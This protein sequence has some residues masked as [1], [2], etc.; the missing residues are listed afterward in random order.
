MMKLPPVI[1]L[2]PADAA[3]PGQR[4]RRLGRDAPHELTV[5]GN[6]ALLAE[7]L[8]ALLCSARCSGA[9]IVRAY[10]QAAH[11]RDTGR[12]VIGGFHSPPEQ[13]CLRILL[14]GPQPVVICPARRLPARLAPELRGPLDAGRLLVLAM[15]PATAR[16][17]TRELAARRNLLVA[18]LATEVWFAHITP[19]GQMAAIAQRAAGW[20]AETPAI[21]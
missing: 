9:A 2:T 14:R 12:A 5:L 7:P 17:A 11:W 19:G 16:R 4:I 8:T 21:G 13:E 20:Q 18:A 6:P 1:T 3:W 15:F 10:D